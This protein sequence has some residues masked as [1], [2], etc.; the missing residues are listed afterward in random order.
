MG[1]L[2]GTPRGK[3][4]PSAIDTD[5]LTEVRDCGHP[6]SRFRSPGGQQPIHRMLGL[7]AAEVALKLKQTAGKRKSEPARPICARKQP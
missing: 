6:V 4:G 7:R 3:P 1:R 5:L 2:H